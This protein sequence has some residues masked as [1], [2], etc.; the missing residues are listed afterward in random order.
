VNRSCRATDHAD[1]IGAMHTGF[2]T[3]KLP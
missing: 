3:I 1:R 2:A